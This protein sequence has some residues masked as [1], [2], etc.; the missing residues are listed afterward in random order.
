MQ[1]EHGAWNRASDCQVSAL[2]I[3]LW[4]SSAC[5]M[6]HNFTPEQGGL[7]LGFIIIFSTSCHQYLYSFLSGYAE[8]YIYQSSVKIIS[9]TGMG[10]WFWPMKCEQKK[11][12]SLL[13]W[14]ERCLCPL[15]QA[16]LPLLL[17][18]GS[19][20]GSIKGQCLLQ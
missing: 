2:N 18:Q 13:G 11:S 8:V 5:L 15:L 20:D 14:S 3:F 17:G 19:G 1:V 4:P 16:S 9:R 10:H 12:V 6:L 7:T